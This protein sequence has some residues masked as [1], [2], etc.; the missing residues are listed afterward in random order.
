MLIDLFV[1][2]LWACIGLWVLLTVSDYYL[3]IKGAKMYQRGA[4]K[5]FI[6]SNGY[7]LEPDHQ[8][9]I[10]NLQPISFNFILSLIV[11]S[12][13]LATIYYT[14][15]LKFFMF[16]WG[17]FILLQL[18]VHLRH[19]RNIILF[20]FAQKSEGIRGQIE[21]DHKIS[22]RMSSYDFLSFGLLFL[23]IYLLSDSIFLLGG[24][25]SCLLM[26]ARQIM[27]SRKDISSIE[28]EG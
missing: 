15:S 26:S 13:I 1:K 8:K 19:F 7:E 20:H 22:L 9:E 12:G 16:I 5:H 2:N 17:G 23:F 27:L 24:G 25:A 10:A 21:Y 11:Y 14:M 3:T 28:P 4:N 18:A 6:F